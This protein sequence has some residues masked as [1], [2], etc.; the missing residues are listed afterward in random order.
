MFEA[1]PSDTFQPQ[2]LDLSSFVVQDAPPQP[3]AL[4][5]SSFIFQD[6]PPE[7]QALD[8]SSFIRDLYPSDLT[9]PQALDVSSFVYP[10]D[11]LSHAELML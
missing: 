2:A 4:D 3:Q 11:L 8:L 1:F 9:Q 6:A 5:L 7:P 10:T